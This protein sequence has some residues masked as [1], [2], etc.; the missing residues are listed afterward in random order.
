MT[1]K[2]MLEKARAK[3]ERADALIARSGYNDDADAQAEVKS[4]LAEVADLCQR[5]EERRE[6]QTQARESRERLE[7]LERTENTPVN[8]TQPSQPSTSQPE[9]VARLR[10]RNELER[11]PHAENDRY[12]SPDELVRAALQS[13]SGL[14][15]TRGF[16][17]R[18]GFKEFLGARIFNTADGV[19]YPH[20]EGGAAFAD[21]H[22]FLSPLNLI[23]V[24]PAVP[25]AEPT[26]TYR[27]TA[28]F[29]RPTGSIYLT[30]GG[31]Y[32]L[33]N[34]PFTKVPF[35][36]KD[37]GMAAEYTDNVQDDD[38]QGISSLRM[39]L[40][41]DL[42]RAVQTELAVGNGANPMAATIRGLY[43]AAGLT[44]AKGS[45][46]V[47]VALIKALKRLEAAFCPRPNV[48][49][50]HSNDF[51]DMMATVAQFPVAVGNAVQQGDTNQ[52]IIERLLVDGPNQR[53]LG[54]PVIFVNDLTE[55]QALVGFVAERTV[56]ISERRDVTLVV[57][58]VSYYDP[59][60]TED[61]RTQPST[62]QAVCGKVRL[63]L[64][65]KLDN[66]FCKV[67]GI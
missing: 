24:L 49:L 41:D 1:I 38:P 43:T 15:T 65:V 64:N 17:G 2:E 42:R 33:G 13:G 50:M 26:G 52:P 6:E 10:G 25:A 55:G 14:F 12:N 66:A 40:S 44:Q 19:G 4:L 32:P 27:H 9:H 59:T 37:L 31:A 22:N 46:P 29:S 62:V 21:A 39:G 57:K 54:I 67:T 18:M 51:F 3:Q 20:I 35:S 48:I 34:M 28:G 7:G 53:F 36:I 8:R 61:K 23:D 16:T 45:D 30:D 47:W 58:D 56:V 5:A 60:A 63:T 11:S